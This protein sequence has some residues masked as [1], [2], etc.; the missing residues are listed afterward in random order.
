MALR[1]LR[2]ALGSALFVLVPGGL[3][4]AAAGSVNRSASL[5]GAFGYEVRSDGEAEPAF[6]QRNLRSKQPAVRFSWLMK[7]EDLRF[8][9]GTPTG[10]RV[11]IARAA[12]AKKLLKLKKARWEVSLEKR[13]ASDEP[14]LVLTIYEQGRSSTDFDL[15]PV[16]RQAWIELNWVPATTSSSNDGVV[17]VF[18][19]GEETV[20]ANDLDNRSRLKAFGIGMLSSPERVLEETSI[21]FDRVWVTHL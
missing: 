20:V 18:R 21:L 6:V 4:F 1:I 15:G 7:G 3:V 2:R 12:V 13:A 11:V 5:S 10:T 16:N 9:A 17:T 8:V 19:N 14:A